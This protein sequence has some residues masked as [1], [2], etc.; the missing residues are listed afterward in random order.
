MSRAFSVA[1]FPGGFVGPLKRYVRADRLAPVVV[2]H[3]GTNGVLPEAMLRQMLDLLSGTPR[4]VVVNTN[5][6]RKWRSPNNQVID[7]VVADYSNAVIADW[8]AASKDQRDYFVSDG[9]HLTS[10]GARAYAQVIK[11]ATGL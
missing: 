4:V 11:E 5:M 7:R 2:L 9:I 8:Y 10:S 3:P 6:P 1:R